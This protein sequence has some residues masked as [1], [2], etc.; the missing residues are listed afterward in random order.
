MKLYVRACSLMC[1]LLV[2]VCRPARADDPIDVVSDQAVVV[3]HFSSVDR[4]TG[5]LNEMLGAIGPLAQAVA[6]VEM[7]LGELLH[8]P[9]K[10]DSIDRSAPTLAALFH[11]PGES[12]PVAFVVRTKDNAK[13]RRAVLDAGD[14]DKLEV[15]KRSDGIERVSRGSTAW[16]FASRGDWVLYTS[17]EAV[18][19]SMTVSPE[20]SFAKLLDAGA[21]DMIKTGDVAGVVNLARVVGLFQNEIGQ[22]RQQ[23]LQQVDQASDAD[24]SAA[25][26]NAAVARSVLRDLVTAAFDAV[27]DARLATGRANFNAEGAAAE[28]RL[29]FDPGSRVAG[30]LA[31]HPPTTFETLG[32]LP[33][34]AP[35]YYAAYANYGLLADWAAD[36][37]QSLLRDN[38]DLSK[39]L[40]GTFEQLRKAGLGQ[41][42]ASFAFPADAKSGLIGT[43]LAQ[44]KDVSALRTVFQ[45]YES[46]GQSA[47]ANPMFT[48]TTEL[49]EKAETYKNRPVDLQTTRVKF[50]A[51][52]NTDLAIIDGFF[53]RFFGED[54]LQTRITAIEGMLIQASGNDPKYLARVVDAIESGEGVLGL[55]EAFAKTRDK[56]GKEA[57]FIFLFNVP[58]VIV[59][60]V[61]AFRDIPPLDMVLGQLPFNFDA[62]PAASYGGFSIG[63]EST[64]V[65]VHVYVPVSQPK[66]VLGIFGQG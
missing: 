61:R 58:Q 8:L 2:T 18:A 4:L 26:V 24:L 66:G 50:D 27:A 32:L 11:M 56:L 43:S 1:L 64:G 10:L 53:K 35:F 19:K 39:Q 29:T 42:V 41:L 45:G 51:G 37:T 6:S 48:Q 3:V 20:H 65:R 38:D 16:Y 15:E 9:G 33:A 31:A 44:A 54:G 28:A 40:Q 25:G 14:N 59:D 21:R 36:L 34:G 62:T 13:L 5:N 47:P 63:T 30:L 46:L 49:K 23:I 17:C 12:E 52:A 22:S 7:G 55:N 60:F 57:N